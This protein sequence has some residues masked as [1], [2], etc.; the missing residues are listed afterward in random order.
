MAQIQLRRDTASNWQTANP[1]LAQGEV[2]VDLTN[3]TIKLGDGA[4]AW[5]NLND[6]AG[7][8]ND[9]TNKPTINGVTVNGALTSS[10]LGLQNTLT[11]GNNI[12]ITEDGTISATG[13]GEAPAN[14]VTTDTDQTITG[15]KTIAGN[16]ALNFGTSGSKIEYNSTSGY[17]SITSNGRL[18]FNCSYVYAPNAPI[19]A[20]QY[21]VD[22]TY[23]VCS[24]DSSTTTLTFGDTTRKAIF[25]CNEPLTIKRNGQSYT[26][27]DSGNI[28]TTLGISFWKGT[29]TEYESIATKDS[30][31]LYIITGA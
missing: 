11:A 20:K 30:N 18:G 21:Q 7:S 27:I 10:D 8:Y 5:N 28:T 31:T 26:N 12:T 15:E 13:G 3:K 23:N 19:R 17:L 1:I 9:V 4:T 14:M 29:Q 2:G 6:Y 25:Q 16:T 22:T 24:H